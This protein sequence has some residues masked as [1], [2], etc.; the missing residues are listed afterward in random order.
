VKEFN[1]RSRDR[2]IGVLGNRSGGHMKVVICRSFVLLFAL[3]ALAVYGINAQLPPNGVEFKSTFPFVV[4]TETYPAGTYTIKPTQEDPDVLAITGAP[5]HA[6]FSYCE[7]YDA[8]SAATKTE[9]TFNKYGSTGYLK[10]ISV[11]NS[12]QGCLLA[13]GNAEKKAKKSGK[14]TKEAVEGNAK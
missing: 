1:L 11:S 7:E 10:Q 5:G 12:A 4:G 3:G 13:T 8:P 14:P 9:L 2:R 6:G